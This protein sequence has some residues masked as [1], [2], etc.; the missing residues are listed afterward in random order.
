MQNKQNNKYLK[1]QIESYQSMKNKF[2]GKPFPYRFKSSKYRWTH[3][4]ENTKRSLNITTNYYN[5][6]SQ[7]MIYNIR[8]NSNIHE[9]KKFFKN[10]SLPNF[11][12]HK[13]DSVNILYEN[14]KYKIISNKIEAHEYT[15]KKFLKVPY[16]NYSCYLDRNNM[17]CLKYNE[18][19]ESI[20]KNTIK[21]IY[22]INNILTKKENK[23]PRMIKILKQNDKIYKEIFSRP[24]KYPQLF[25]YYF[26]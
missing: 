24:W 16:F 6:S 13:N 23:L 12:V 22:Q 9:N 18:P 11:R 8:K 5:N 25:E 2:V 10:E 1:E 15:R 17:F 7:T 3:S 26:K 14:Q 4:I 20:R 19:K 21:F